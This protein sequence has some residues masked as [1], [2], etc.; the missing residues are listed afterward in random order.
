V[1]RGIARGARYLEKKL[2]RFGAA[3]GR[4]IR[5]AATAVK[6]QWQ[7]L[8]AKFGEW[9]DKLKK[10]W[11]DW[12]KGAE[13]RKKKRLDAA[14]R[15][16]RVALG[17]GL[18]G[19]ALRAYLLYLRVRYWL[20]SA[21][22]VGE[23]D[24]AV[25]LLRINPEAEETL[26]TKQVPLHDGK[27]KLIAVFPAD[28]EVLEDPVLGARSAEIVAKAVELFDAAVKA[29]EKKYKSPS[30]IGRVA[31]AQAERDLKAWAKSQGIRGLKVGVDFKGGV[32]LGPPHG[33]HSS[34]VRYA[35]GN[36]IL[37][38]KL[39][40]TSRRWKQHKH[41][42]KFCVDNGYVLVYVSAR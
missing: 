17:K 13:D 28:T 11:D 38:F 10:K 1:G 27:A 36:L 16:L 37:D 6:K 21:V 31:G 15:A 20:A 9:R 30:A 14:A 34:D 18:S 25:V 4:G 29:A 24:D 41:F 2:G 40:S 23:G 19:F 3:M 39:S 7:K 42:L 35:F 5:G 26:K 32:A 8:K 22:L 12:K 33:K